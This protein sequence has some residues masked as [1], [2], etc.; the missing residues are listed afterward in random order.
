MTLSRPDVGLA[1]PYW[2]HEIHRE[3]SHNF[4]RET[5]NNLYPFSVFYDAEVP[6]DKRT[7]G[8]ARNYFMDL[9]LDDCLDVM[10]ICDADT[11]CQSDA[12]LEAIEF[13]DMFGGLNYPFNRFRAL[14][15]STT[16]A[17]LGGRIG[18]YAPDVDM[19]LEMAC[20]GSLGGVMVMQPQQWRDAGW[21]PEL[22]GWGFEDVIFAVQ[23]RTL[24]PQENTWHNGTIT[25]MYHPTECHVGSE[26]YNENISVC[27]QYEAADRNPEAIRELL[28]TRNGC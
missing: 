17:V 4:V 14:N 8:A 10:V 6:E 15:Q 22:H 19:G 28:S 27:K 24:L 23:A 26:S 21:M 20:A 18:K 13:C 16:A 2:G 12:L 1:I 9:A 25:H 7:R 11:Y 3:F 5:M